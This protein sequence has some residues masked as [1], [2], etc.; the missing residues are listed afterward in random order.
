MAHDP[1]TVLQQR[2]ATIKA[3]LA[4]LGPLRPGTLSQQYNV[5]GTPGCRCKADP[6]QRHGPYHQLSYTWRGRSRSE[7]V[8]E[9]ELT[10]VREQ[11]AN[12]ARLRE[13]LDQW[14]DAAIEL[15]RL[16]RQRW[17]YPQ[18]NSRPQARLPRKRRTP[19]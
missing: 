2:I 6:A 8:R 19:R 3:A 13:L 17:R 12:Y 15:A 9:P 7:F 11:L 5:C 16:E 10:R 14:L 18:E 1:H 4:A